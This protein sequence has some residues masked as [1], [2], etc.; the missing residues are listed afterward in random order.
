M[1]W[2]TERAGQEK[3]TYWGSVLE[4]P[5]SRSLVRVS[6]KQHREWLALAKTNAVRDAVI[7]RNYRII[8]L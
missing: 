2:E 5:Y 3:A 7:R 1:W 8:R 6:R 4:L